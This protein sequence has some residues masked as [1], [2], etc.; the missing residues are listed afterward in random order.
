[1]DFGFI[2]LGTA[3]MWGIIVPERDKA[4]VRRGE[5]FLP[6]YT[7]HL[8]PAHPEG[9]RDLAISQNRSMGFSP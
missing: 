9:K 2:F 1:M 4:V 3:K 8:L 6:S 7:S 5:N